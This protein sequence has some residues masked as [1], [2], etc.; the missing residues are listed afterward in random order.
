MNGWVHITSYT[1]PESN[2]TQFEHLYL[3]DQEL[4]W[5]ELAEREFKAHNH[6]LIA[7]FNAIGTRD[8]AQLLRGRRLAATREDFP[9]PADNEYY[10]T[11]LIGTRVETNQGD[12]LGVVRELVDN[13]ASSILV[14][15]D[16]STEHL[17][18][19]QKEF[20]ELIEIPERIVVNWRKD[21]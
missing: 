15:R 5:S 17:I 14:V 21:W 8:E 1:D 13:G 7:R 6:R 2:L 3:E 18:P 12:V 16:D 20:L 10:W 9:K 11:D 19:M 4:K